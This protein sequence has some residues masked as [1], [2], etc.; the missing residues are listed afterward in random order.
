MRKTGYAERCEEWAE[1]RKRYKISLAFREAWRQ[2]R[3]GLQAANRPI[4]PRVDAGPPQVTLGRF[5]MASD[6]QHQVRL[7]APGNQWQ[8]QECSQI[9]DNE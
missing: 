8:C 6:C 5:V 7:S 4:P 1:W 2:R 9:F 3:Y